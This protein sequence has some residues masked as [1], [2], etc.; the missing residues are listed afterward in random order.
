MDLNPRQFYSLF[1]LQ[2]LGENIA[3]RKNIN[4]F[5]FSSV[6]IAQ[7]FSDTI[8]PAYTLYILYSILLRVV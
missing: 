1:S 2:K 6:L 8:K 3:K 7:C 5:S 4:R